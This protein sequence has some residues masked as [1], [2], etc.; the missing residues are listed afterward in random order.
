MLQYSRE[1][2][3]SFKGKIGTEKRQTHL[4]IF[5]VFRRFRRFWRVFEVLEARER[6]QRHPVGRTLHFHRI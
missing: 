2:L 4:F 3:A 6:F 1:L 5:Y